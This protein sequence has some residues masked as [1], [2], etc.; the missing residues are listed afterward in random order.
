MDIGTVA[1]ACIPY[2]VSIWTPLVSAD[3]V[4]V[5]DGPY[6]SDLPTKYL[7]VGFNDQPDVPIITGSQSMSQVGNNYSED[8]ISI[9]NQMSF[10]TGDMTYVDI[11]ND[12]ATTLGL[13]YQSLRDDRQLGG[14]VQP[15]GFAWP[16]TY[17]FRQVPADQTVGA[18][19][20]I[21]IVDFEVAILVRAWEG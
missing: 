12:A 16:G 19:G 18:G 20:S 13:L 3:G 7:S 11:R 17:T 2:L 21:V 15:P 5:F 6:T 1:T 14:N 4:E 9:Q 8:V 10:A